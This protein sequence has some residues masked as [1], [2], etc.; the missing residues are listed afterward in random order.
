MLEPP[1][2]PG[3]FIPAFFPRIV[4]ESFFLLGLFANP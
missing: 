4:A 1:Q 3:R 2:N